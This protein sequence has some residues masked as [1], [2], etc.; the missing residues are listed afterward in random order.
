MNQDSARERDPAIA[1]G[2]RID[3]ELE[4]KH[5]ARERMTLVV[6]DDA[7][8]DFDK[9][10]LGAGTPL[11]RT[12]LGHRAGETLAYP[13]GDIVRVHILKV[14]PAAV[15]AQDAAPGEAAE[16]RDQMLRRAR[17]KA[18]LASMVSFALT[19][20]SKWG[21]Y[22]PEQIVKQYE[23]GEAD[24]ERAE[25]GEPKPDSDAANT[26]PSDARKDKPQETPP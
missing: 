4:A 2:S 12:L 11:A 3:I 1:S 18:D 21:D 5:K 26:D 19:F 7:S 22:D 9:G 15:T 6:V 16:A 24:K 20:D 17:D 10:F 23:E 25:Q 8:A 14:E 13:R